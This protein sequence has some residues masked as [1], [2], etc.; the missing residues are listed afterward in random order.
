MSAKK[1]APP[2]LDAMVDT[3]LAHKPKA[4]FAAQKKRAKK[5]KKVQREESSI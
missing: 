2:A 1:K 3:I 5:A 4:K